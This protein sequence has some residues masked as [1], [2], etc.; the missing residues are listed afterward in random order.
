M[1][2]SRLATESASMR[3]ELVDAQ[4]AK[5]NAATLQTK[6]VELEQLL[7]SANMRGMQSTV[8]EQRMDSNGDEKEPH[9]MQA[10]RNIIADVELRAASALAAKECLLAA[11][12]PPTSTQKMVRKDHYIRQYSA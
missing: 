2:N 1:G 8:P 12:V 3:K 5:E 7:D 11:Q 6:M 4:T 9:G 10:L